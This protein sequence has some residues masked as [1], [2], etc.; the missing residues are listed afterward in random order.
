MESAP[1]LIYYK[2][3][4]M[5]EIMKKFEASGAWNLPVINKGKYYGFISKSKLL[6]AYRRKLIDFSGN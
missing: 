5:Q 4:T 6:T 2:E 3:D 1:S